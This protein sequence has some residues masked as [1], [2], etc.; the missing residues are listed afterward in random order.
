[1]YEYLINWHVYRGNEVPQV[2]RMSKRGKMRRVLLP[3]VEDLVLDGKISDERLC[4]Y[5][6]VFG[7]G[8]NY[9]VKKVPDKKPQYAQKDKAEVDHALYDL[10]N[11]KIKRMVDNSGTDGR[12]IVS[13][14]KIES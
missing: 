7:V 5:F 4:G 3:E 8:K 14:R 2:Y 1:M 6:K 10:L 12:E 9:L 13:G 11:G